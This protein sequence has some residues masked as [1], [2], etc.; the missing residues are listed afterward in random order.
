MY[1]SVHYNKYALSNFPIKIRHTALTKA[2]ILIHV[3]KC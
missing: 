1:W 3:L 2:I